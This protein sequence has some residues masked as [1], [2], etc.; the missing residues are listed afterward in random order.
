MYTRLA[1]NLSRATYENSILITAKLPHMEEDKELV[2]SEE[3]IVRVRGRI[4]QI[5]CRAAS[6]SLRS[7]FC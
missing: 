6:K 7:G 4:R 2:D 3:D 1:S 5:V